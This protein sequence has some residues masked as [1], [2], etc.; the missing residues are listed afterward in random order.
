MRRT[1]PLTHVFLTDL[2]DNGNRSGWFDGDEALYLNWSSEK[3]CRIYIS[4]AP[5][6]RKKSAIADSIS[7]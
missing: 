2:V 1:P 4:V 7:S 6:E 5:T 3:G